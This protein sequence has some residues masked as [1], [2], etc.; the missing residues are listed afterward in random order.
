MFNNGLKI[1]N[2]TLNIGWIDK[3]GG[4]NKFAM[5]SANILHFKTKYNWGKLNPNQVG[6]G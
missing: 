3:S 4:S 2:V 5:S 1:R 6:Q